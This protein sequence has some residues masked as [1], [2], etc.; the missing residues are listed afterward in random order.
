MSYKGI[1]RG[2]MIELEGKVVL[3]EGTEV[4]V[5]VREQ[6]DEALSPSGHPKSSREAIL[7][8]LDLPA[9][10]VPGDVDALVEEIERGKRPLRLEGVF[11]REAKRT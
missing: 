10:C 6:H 2:K 3:P 1:V 11:D 7:A 9:R 5:V 8:A 4:E